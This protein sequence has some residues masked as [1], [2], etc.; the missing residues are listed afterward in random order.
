MGAR[1]WPWALPRRPGLAFCHAG[2][3]W[4]NPCGA[5]LREV[6]LPPPAG[7]VPALGAGLVGVLLKVHW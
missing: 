3:P 6:V 2:L 1:W 4:G 7:P 5:G